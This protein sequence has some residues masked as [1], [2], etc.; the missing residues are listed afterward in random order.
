MQRAGDTAGMTIKVHALK[1][2]SRMIGAEALGTEAERLEMAGKAGDAETLSGGIGGLLARY[3]ALAERLAPLCDAPRDES[4]YDALPPVPEEK[5]REAYDTLRET[6]AAMDYDSV[7]FVL[8][9][10]DG[11]RLPEEERVRCEKIRNAADNFDWDQIEGM[12]P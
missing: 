3:R 8:N 10:L 1:S 11:Y 2:T 7:E 4:E 5:L 9:F 6:L 12:L